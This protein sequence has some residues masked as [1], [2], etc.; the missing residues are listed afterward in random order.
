MT[1]LSPPKPLTNRPHLRELDWLMVATVALCCLGLVMAVSVR[2]AQVDVGPLQAMK[3]Q[4][5]KLL[6]GLVAFLV[7]ALT[8]M[9]VLRRFALP[10]FFVTAAACLLPHLTPDVKGA[11]RWIRLPGLQLQPVEPARICL[12]LC[13]ASLLSR[14]GAGISRF[15]T[16]FVPAMGCTV[17]LAGVLALQ[18]DNG[19]ALIVI[20]LASCLAL[21]AGVRLRY[22]A[23]FGVVAL[24]GLLAMA[25]QH[26]YVRNRLTDFLHT[27]PQSQVGLGL[28]AVGSGGSFGRGLGQGWM[29][30]NYVPEAHNDFVFA[31]IGEEFGFLGSSFVLLAFSVFGYACY[32]LVCKVRDP[33]LRYLICGYALMI[34][35]QAA[36]NLL[37]V[38]GWAPAKGIDLP[39]V[40]TGGTSLMFCLAA[41]G[42][43]GNAARTDRTG[44]ATIDA[45]AVS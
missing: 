42:L 7:A 32:R 14:A 26:E 31:I 28:I 9:R 27:K 41:V 40:S 29:K 36:M 20:V 44:E 3:Q 13:L 24:A 8:P 39:F 6:A 17:L 33:F 15:R 19:N 34:C 43:I 5:S 35:L 18:P 22:F 45:E 12:V 38:S 16:G 1:A 21:I 37:V 10:A 11:S 25:L 2:G 23:S 30:M 4:G